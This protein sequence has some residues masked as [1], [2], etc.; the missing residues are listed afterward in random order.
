MPRGTWRLDIK[1]DVDAPALASTTVLVEDFLPERIDF[2]LSPARGGHPPRPDRRSDR[3]GSG[4]SSA[5]RAATCRSRAT[6]ILRARAQRRRSPQAISSAVTIPA[7][8]RA[9]GYFEGDRTGADG[10]S[11]I[12][13]SL[14]EAPAAD[15][16]LELEVITRVSEGSGR[17]VERRLTH[18][19][20]PAGPVIGIKPMFDDVVEEGTQ[21]GFRLIALSADLKPAQMRVKWTLNRVNR[22]YQW[23]QEYGDW[24]WEI[25]TTRKKVTEGEATLGDAPV[26]VSAPV[27]WGSYE[28]V[29]ERLDGDYVASS[30]DFY[31]GWYVPAD[32]A[33]TPDVL[34]LSL[35]RPGYVS[36]DTAQLRLVPRYAG[37]ALVTVMSNRLIAIEGGRGAERRKPDPAR[38]DR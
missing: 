2:D 9:A 29:V 7:P 17:P 34:D 1:A 16:P 24:N 13:V 27:D 35:D 8:P 5:H 31:A 38:R 21:A 18:H 6:P 22:R 30:A 25:V 10:I 15:R 36:G 14:P 37:T 26:E 33:S 28:L 3:C 23:Y 19:V 11:T 32:T 12:A 20:A 4:I